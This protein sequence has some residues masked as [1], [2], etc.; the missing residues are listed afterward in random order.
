LEQSQ[1]P[2]IVAGGGT[3]ASSAGLEIAE[4]A[5]MLSI[6]VATS[7]NGK[8]AL[9]E[10]HPLNMGVVGSYS[11]W[12]ANRVVSEADLVLFIGS[13]TGDQVTNGWKVP[14]PGTPVIQVDID[15]SELG[16]NYPNLVGLLGDARVTIRRFI[17][18]VNPKAKKD[19]WAQYAQKIV[20]E[21]RQQTEP[22]LNSEDSPIRPERLC[23]EI[24]DSLP[25]N[26]VLVADTGFSGIWTGTMVNLTDPG[27]TYLRAAGTLGWSLPASLGAKCAAPERPV[28]CFL[29]D[30]AMWYHLS[31]LETARRCGINTVI[32][33][34]NNHCLSQTIAGVHRAYGDR[35]GKKH[36][37]YRFEGVNFA[38][39]AQEM[40]CR[41]IRVERPEDISGALKTALESDIATVVDV[42]TDEQCRP[43]E[44]W[45]PDQPF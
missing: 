9:L 35:P 10:N 32:V 45:T 34:N 42:V 19:H 29:G 2:V 30:G 12:C 44:P 40:G 41:G 23:K 11:R 22:L 8:G 38:R 21:Y 26:A 3:V 31:E 43:L 24:T 27:Q 5:E 7:L 28:V 17:E 4:F 13:R 18:T 39:I 14:K 36:E 16:R 15:P 37:L 6:P 33:V 1:R 20:E 25:S